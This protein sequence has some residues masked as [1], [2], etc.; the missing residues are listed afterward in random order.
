MLFSTHIIE[1]VQKRTYKIS[2]ILIFNSTDKIS[3][4]VL[5]FAPNLKLIARVGVGLDGIDLNYAKKGVSKL[6]Y[7]K[8]PTSAVAE[9]ALANMLTLIRN[10]HISNIEIHNKKWERYFG[11]DLSVIPIGIM[12][13]GKIGSL[14]IKSF[15]F[16]YKKN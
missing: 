10:I 3:K 8:A 11:Y 15:F 5:D 12:G 4:K 16:R 6:L 7:Q 2:R 9:L 14:V 13:S 1:N